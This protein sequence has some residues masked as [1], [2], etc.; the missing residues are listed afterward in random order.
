MLG[1]HINDDVETSRDVEFKCQQNRRPRSEGSQH[2]H[3]HPFS[4]Q[5]PM[6]PLKLTPP[7]TRNAEHGSNTH[8]GVHQVSAGQPNTHTTSISTSSSISL[9]TLHCVVQ[10]R[11]DANFTM[12]SQPALEHL[13]D[14]RRAL[15]AMQ[16]AG[17][18]PFRYL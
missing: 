10:A 4:S 16:A 12:N 13:P 15:K 5:V 6:D 1:L 9:C 14:H 2:H 18:G 7:A 8:E 17:Y 3:K 11:P